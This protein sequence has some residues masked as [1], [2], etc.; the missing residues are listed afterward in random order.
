MGPRCGSTDRQGLPLNAPFKMKVLDGV[1]WTKEKRLAWFF[2]P[3]MF[4]LKLMTAENMC[5]SWEISKHLEG[6]ILVAWGG[7]GGGGRVCIFTEQQGVG[8]RLRVCGL[9][10]D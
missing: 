5:I 4:C 9:H 1:Y 3:H 2:L 10:R 8:C 6:K 7:S